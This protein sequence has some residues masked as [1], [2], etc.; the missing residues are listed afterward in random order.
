MAV[1]VGVGLL[2]LTIT[3]FRFKNGPHCFHIW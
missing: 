3:K 1:L 2:L